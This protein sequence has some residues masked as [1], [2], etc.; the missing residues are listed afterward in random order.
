MREYILLNGMETHETHWFD[1]LI[2]VC[3]FCASEPS[4][5]VWPTLSTWRWKDGDPAEWNEM[6]QT[7]ILINKRWFASTH[8]DNAKKKREA[9]AGTRA[10]KAALPY[11]RAVGV[12]SGADS[13]PGPDGE[14]DGSLILLRT[15]SADTS[16]R[17]ALCP[18][19]TEALWMPKRESS[20]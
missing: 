1:L 13:W 14:G 17:R 8:V 11:L 10:S 7:Q 9:A 12:S 6:P 20:T 4:C 3:C 2:S 16:P 18:V 5:V 19:D 15:G